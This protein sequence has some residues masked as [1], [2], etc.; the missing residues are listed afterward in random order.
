[1]AIKVMWAPEVYYAAPAAA[2]KDAQKVSDELETLDRKTPEAILELARNENTELHG[3]FEWD[4]SVAAEKYRLTQAREIV[5]LL[6]VA[7]DDEIQDAETPKYIR[8]YHRT[9]SAGGY[10][11]IH[12]ILDSRD[13]KLELVDN[14]YRDL[15]AFSNKYT[16]LS[17]VTGFKAAMDSAA[18]SLRRCREN[19]ETARPTA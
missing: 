16:T 8:A 2:R 10:E 4:D 11:N 7:K 12:K 15:I 6:V 9:R 18:D 17:D 13:K 1:M 19:A 14:A 5:R 3:C